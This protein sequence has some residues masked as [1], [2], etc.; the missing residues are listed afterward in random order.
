MKKNNVDYI[1]MNR[2]L[3]DVAKGVRVKPGTEESGIENK[4]MIH[5]Y[6]GDGKGKTTA[7]VGLS[8]RVAGHGRC[9]VFAQFLKGRKTGELN[10]LIKM[11]IR[12]VRSEDNKRFCWEM[13]DEEKEDCR[14]IQTKLLD[15]IVQII[16]GAESDTKVDVLILDEAL[17][18]LA[19][20]MLDEKKLRDFIIQ[21]PKGLE[22][23]LTGFSAPEWLFEMA[24][25]VTEMKKHKHPFD[26]EINGREAIEY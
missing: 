14:V 23:V 9:V 19:N 3:S 11:D 16:Q 21:K 8:A 26:S 5:V 10:S 17:N 2:N 4:G 12:V 13:K 25:Y 18:A 22:I 15:E 24:D 7:A 6:Y 1:K 20:G